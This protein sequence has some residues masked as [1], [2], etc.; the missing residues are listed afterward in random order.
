MEMYI[1]EHCP[2]CARVRY[3]A[4]SL[5]I[6]IKETVVDYDDNTTINKFIGTKMVPLLIKE[7]GE[8]MAESGDIIQYLLSLKNHPTAAPATANTLDWQSRAF[9]LLQAI[10]YPRWANL[11]LKE[12]LKPESK[13]L[14]R[15]KKHTQTLNFERLLEQTGEIV[16]YL[17]PLI[18]EAEK[19]LCFKDGVSQLPLIDQAIYF[20]ILRGF[21]SEDSVQW[22]IQLD[23]WMQNQSTHLPLSLLK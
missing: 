5:G 22:P 9:P 23:T 3:V 14:W 11:S 6:Q 21:Y 16:N 2:F 10:G 4:A 7:D 19:Y 17:N 8:P 1:Y 15:E 13:A 18:L 20:S 12:F